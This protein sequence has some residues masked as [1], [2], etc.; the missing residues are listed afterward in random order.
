MIVTSLDPGS[1]TDS[2]IWESVEIV[3]LDDEGRS[4][5]MAS[6][7]Q[8]D[9]RLAERMAEPGMAGEPDLDLRLRALGAVPV[10]VLTLRVDLAGHFD[11]EVRVLDIRPVILERIPPLNGTLFSVPPQA[12]TPA[13]DMTFD[14]DELSPTARES[15]QGTPFFEKQSISLTDKQQETITIR[16]F[17]EQYCVTFFLRMK[18]LVGDEVKEKDLYGQGQ[19]FRVTG[20]SRDM[21]YRRAFAVIGDSLQQAPDPAALQS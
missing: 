5:A 20:L 8:P 13:M 14:M 6:V 2:E 18:Y 21:R 16:T 3:Y 17:A 4:K 12:G 1:H 19:P 10:H 7:F 9:A 15:G 11:R